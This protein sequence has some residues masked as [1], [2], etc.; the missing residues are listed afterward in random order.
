MSEL[1][2]KKPAPVPAG[3]GPSKSSGVPGTQSQISR[4]DQMRYDVQQALHV[5]AYLDAAII[6]NGFSAEDIVS[7]LRALR[8]DELA[9]I[10]AA[11]LAG[12]PGWS[13]PVVQGIDQVLVTAKEAERVRKLNEA[14]DNAV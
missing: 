12:M 2:T 10:R 7:V 4:R 8:P 3:A 1:E 13:D 5:R 6:L 14:F 9:E 11:A